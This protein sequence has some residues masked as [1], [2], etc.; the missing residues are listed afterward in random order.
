MNSLEFPERIPMDRVR[1][2]H[3]S[4]RCFVFGLIGTIPILGLSM[5]W[6]AMRLKRQVASE[7]GETVRLRAVNMATIAAVAIIFPLLIAECYSAAFATVAA[8]LC[9]EFFLLHRQYQKT[10]PPEWNPARH[11]LY[12][13]V[14]LAYAG[15]IFSFTLLIALALAIKK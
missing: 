14:G 15:Y 11:L 4:S 13:G 7:T 2:I 6:L 9:M 3:R 8:L 1:I 10:I 5:A 12:W